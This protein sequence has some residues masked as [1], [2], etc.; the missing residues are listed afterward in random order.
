MGHNR[1]D[2]DNVHIG[3]SGRIPVTVQ[4]PDGSAVSLLGGEMRFGVIPLREQDRPLEDADV[5]VEKTLAGGGIDAVD[6]AAGEARVLLEPS[7]TE[8]LAEKAYWYRI[9][10]VDA[11][12]DPVPGA[13]AGVFELVR[14]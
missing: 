5:L 1:T 11:D 13:A 4:R 2:I 8:A 9:N 6:L 14:D 3:Q 12:G 7:D 10:I